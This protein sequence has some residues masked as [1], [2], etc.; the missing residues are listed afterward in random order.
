MKRLLAILILLGCISANAANV[1][2]VYFELRNGTNGGLGS[3]SLTLTPSNAPIKSVNAI[4]SKD[5]LQFSTD[6]NGTVTVSNIA[7][8]RWYCVAKGPWVDT[9][10]FI[11]VP[12][13]NATLNASD[14]L[15]A[16]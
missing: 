12:D 2:N 8:L 6:T 14:I 7:P 15:S 4:I 1:A 10:F 5:R 16:P 3:V 9:S 13:T 11:T